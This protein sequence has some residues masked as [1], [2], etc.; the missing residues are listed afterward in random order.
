MACS[1]PSPPPKLIE[2]VFCFLPSSLIYVRL[3]LFWHFLF[4]HVLLASCCCLPLYSCS[5][6]CGFLQVGEEVVEQQAE[7]VPAVPGAPVWEV[8][9]W[10]S[11]VYSFSYLWKFA[12]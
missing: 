1:H 9:G 6:T 11:C 4:S 8:I 10:A 5:Y 12:Q 7:L 3:I 2:V